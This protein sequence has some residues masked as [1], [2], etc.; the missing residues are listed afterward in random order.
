MTLIVL[1]L[2]HW[3]LI[4]LKI[5]FY[6]LDVWF[7]FKF[8]LRSADARERNCPVRINHGSWNLSLTACETQGCGRGWF[9]R[10]QYTHSHGIC[11]QRQVYSFF[12]N[13][14]ACFL[15][16][17]YCISQGFQYCA[18]R[19]VK[20]TTLALP[21]ILVRKRLASPIKYPVAS[22]AVIDVIYQVEEAP[23][24]ICWGFHLCLRP[25]QN[26]PVSFHIYSPTLSLFLPFF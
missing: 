22:R 7:H 23:S 25:C 10:T 18:E 13:F 1:S 12:I 19:S 5:S 2:I 8:H 14:V 17:S 6:Y 26:F 4:A 3:N 21:L 11:S 24:L 20:G 15:F 9:S 16:T